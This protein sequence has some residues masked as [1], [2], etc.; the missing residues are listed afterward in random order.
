MYHQQRGF[1]MSDQERTAAAPES[2]PAGNPVIAAAQQALAV[3]ELGEAVAGMKK[4]MK[5]LW[6]T[7][8]VI[9]V[10]AVASAVF[11]IG[12]RVGLNMGMGF[13]GGPGGANW[14]RPDRAG[15]GG[16]LPGGGAG[17][18]APDQGAPTTA[19]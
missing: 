14:Q 15:V 4:K 9:G 2:G 11:A 5:T 19:P 10:I 18:G 12:P 6:I 17:P 8:A 7:V 1:D 13:G 3:R 16:T